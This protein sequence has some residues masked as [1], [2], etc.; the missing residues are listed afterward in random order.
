MSLTTFSFA[1]G[2]GRTGSPLR[3]LAALE[4]CDIKGIGG[5]QISELVVNSSRKIETCL[6][7]RGMAVKRQQQK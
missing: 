7:S 6:D 2:K 4:I 5:S 1:K 3:Y